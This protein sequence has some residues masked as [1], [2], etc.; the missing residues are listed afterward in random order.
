MRRT[1]NTECVHSNSLKKHVP[2]SQILPRVNVHHV[3]IMISERTHGNV[4]P[5]GAPNSFSSD[6]TSAH[7][8][9]VRLRFNRRP[10]VRLPTD[11]EHNYM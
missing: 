7:F 4:S 3:Y 8:L 9:D 11:C 6:L 5:F 2:P 1:A 10:D